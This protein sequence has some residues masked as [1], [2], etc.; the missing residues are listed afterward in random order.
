MRIKIKVRP[1]VAWDTEMKDLLFG[2][3]DTLSERII[4]TYNM[5]SGGT[6]KI[7]GGTN[8]NLPFGNV[9]VGKGFFIEVD[10]ACDLAINGGAAISLVPA[11][12]TPQKSQN[13]MEAT[14]TQLNIAAQTGTDI[15]G[16][17]VIWGNAS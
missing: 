15:T 9:D 16:R 5:A 4:D 12:A 1:I 14:V 3:D 6:L 7:P 8:E 2:L 13:V 17:F 11:G 10:G